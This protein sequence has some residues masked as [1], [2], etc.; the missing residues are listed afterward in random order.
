MPRS[1]IQ[2]RGLW[3]DTCASQAIP[4][5]ESIWAIVNVDGLA[6]GPV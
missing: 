6:Y 3:P 1:A 4:G 2:E 5:R